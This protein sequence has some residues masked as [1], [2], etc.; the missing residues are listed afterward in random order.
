[1][2]VWCILHS[3]SSISVLTFCVFLHSVL[4]ALRTPAKGAIMH[5]NGTAS[6]DTF[7]KDY[8][9]V[10]GPPQGAW[11][12]VTQDPVHLMVRLRY[13]G[14]SD[15]EQNTVA[16]VWDPQYGAYR[17][18]RFWHR[19]EIEYDGMPVVLTMLMTPWRDHGAT[20]PKDSFEK[21]RLQK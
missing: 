18:S 10:K 19:D 4:S 9:L 8:Y 2:G 13:F 20:A 15:D 5:A 21:V 11:W 7:G 17:S 6:F 14:C 1:M 3:T 12:R 16:F